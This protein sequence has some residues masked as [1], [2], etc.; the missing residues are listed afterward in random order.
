MRRVHSFCALL[1][2][3]KAGWARCMSSH[4]APPPSSCRIALVQMCSGSDVDANVRSCLQA[5]ESASAG[6]A[7]VIFF[8][9]CFLYISGGEAPASQPKPLFTLDHLVLKRFRD[10]ASDHK[11]WL[12]LGGFALKNDGVDARA[13]N[14][15]ALIAADGGV[16]A[17]YKKI[18][19]F[20]ATGQ[21]QCPPPS[22]APVTPLTFHPTSQ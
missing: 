22:R 16:A 10:A 3:I 8:P 4:A 20:D 18:H 5:I 9:E 21:C 11:V 2:P 7:K 19:L 13:H 6:G 14:A 17:V 12:S 1:G 15:H